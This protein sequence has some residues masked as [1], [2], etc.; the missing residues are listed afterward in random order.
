MTKASSTFEVDQ[1]TD[2]DFAPA[3]AAALLALQ[4]FT[5]SLLD[6]VPNLDPRR[7]IDVANALGLDL[8]LAWRM[9]RLAR[10]GDPFDSCRHVPGSGGYRI[11]LDAVRRHGG[12]AEEIARA[13]EAFEAF[14]EVVKRYAGSRRNFEMMVAGLAGKNGD[15]RLDFE[16]HRQMFLGASYVWG[17]QA[18]AVFRADILA[19]SQDSGMAD[20]VTVRGVVGLRRLRP[21]VSWRL[22]NATSIDDRGVHRRFAN[23]T[24]IDDRCKSDPSMPALLLDRCSTPLPTFKIED[25]GGGQFEFEVKGSGVGRQSEQTLVTA[26][27]VRGHE[28]S[29]RTADYHG[30]HQIF[31]LRVPAESAT[32]D[33]FTHRDLVPEGAAVEM[34]HNSDLHHSVARDNKPHRR[35]DRLPGPNRPD[36]LGLGLARTDLRKIEWY[37]EMLRDVFR[38]VGWN[39]DEF[40]LDR[41]AMKYPPVPSSIVLEREFPDSEQPVLG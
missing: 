29:H 28:P 7:P 30:V 16:H 37:P 12:P 15:D 34:I 36:D 1:S 14:Q 39:P 32:F 4:R 25:L 2:Q 11:W 20:L 35:S 23:R 27:L 18:R 21:D 40:H 13:D 24:P 22:S 31:S 3:A 5:S 9:F 26:E 19:P 38:R 10:A 6:S 41:A 8:K 33:L 17:I